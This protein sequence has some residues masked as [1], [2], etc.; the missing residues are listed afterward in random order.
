MRVARRVAKILLSL[1]VFIDALCG[2]ELWRHG[3]PMTISGEEVKH[4]EAS[5][6]MTQAP[7]GAYDYVALIVLIS[8]QLALLAFL[9][10]SRRR[11]ARA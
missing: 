6:R 3:P 2:W 8:I 9:W 4:G 1:M 7:L 11:I 5:F 10:W